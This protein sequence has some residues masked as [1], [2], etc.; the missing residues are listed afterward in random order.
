MA[1]NTKV[2]I[3][4][5]PAVEQSRYTVPLGAELEQISDERKRRRS[6]RILGAVLALLVEVSGDQCGTAGHGDHHW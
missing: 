2:D 3:P 4:V 5:C 6:R 1:V